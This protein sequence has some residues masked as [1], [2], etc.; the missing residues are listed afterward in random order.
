M[1]RLLFSS[2]LLLAA[3]CASSDRMLRMSGG[4]LDEYS[5]PKSSR[6]RSEKY[7]RISRKIASPA[8]SNKVRIA[9]MDDTLVNIWPFFFRNNDYWT[10]LWPMID[11]DPYGFAFRPFYNQEGDDYSILFPLTSW[12]PAAGNG[13]VTLFGWNRNGFGLVPLTW[14]QKK[15]YSGT[16]YYTPLF[17]YNYDTEP[18]HYRPYRKYSLDCKWDRNEVFCFI[19]PAYYGRKVRKDKGAWRWLFNLHYGSPHAKNEWNYRFKGKV[20]FPATGFEYKQYAAKIFET[21]PEKYERSY[22]FLPLWFGSF[23]DNGSYFNRFMLLAGSRKKGIYSGWD[24]MGDIIAGY[25]HEQRDLSPQNC[26]S[27]QSK[28]TFTSWVMLSRFQKEMKYKR[29]G[30]WSKFA[31]L[32]SLGRRRSI[33]NQVKPEIAEA[34][35]QLDPNLKLPETVVDFRTYRLYLEDLARKYEFPVT[36]EYSGMILP[37]LW[38]KSKEKSSFCILPPLLTWWNTDRNESSFT[39]LP[40]LTWISR[41]RRE[42][43]TI[44]MTPLVYYAKEVHRKR[45]GFRILPHDRR[46]AGEYECTELRDRYAVCGLFY[47]GRFGFNAAKAGVD[48]KT[49]DSL[50]VALLNLYKIQTQIDR[51]AAAIAKERSRTDLW[52]TA[53]EIERLKKLIRYEELKERQKKLDEKRSK[54]HKDISKAMNDAAKLDFS[55]GRNAFAKKTDAEKALADFMEKYS[56]LRFYEDIGSGIFF[57]R[58]KYYNGDQSWHLFHIL[59]GGEKSGQRE[60]EHILHL[61]YRYRK[62]GERSEKIF[63]PFVSLIKDGKNSRISFLWRLFSL[64]RRNGRT[65]GHIFFIPF[66]EN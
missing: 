32:V 54:Y 36:P 13:W 57:N 8:R 66:G 6:I 9:G 24:I 4:V 37:L 29:E 60:S 58:K 55:V 33:F 40:L 63:F 50:R 10:I 35:K 47:R 65:G 56:E 48:A 5:V 12:N 61:L 43:K 45:A 20:P 16:A 22:G 31:P 39:S 34:L 52:K 42:D 25:D 11:K 18:L 30:V 23:D 2:V 49:A 14:Q 15:K 51:E 1:K 17:F 3:G 28:T 53:T 59:A 64:S 19:L 46:S 21:L 38:Y 62:E 27:P 44:I 41:S 7:Q 26:W